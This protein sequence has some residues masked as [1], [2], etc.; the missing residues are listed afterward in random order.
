MR[1]TLLYAIGG[2]GAA[3]SGYLRFR[4][5]KQQKIL[6]LLFHG[7]RED[8][9]HKLQLSIDEYRDGR[10]VCCFTGYVGTADFSFTVFINK[11]GSVR[12]YNI[13]CPFENSVMALG[14]LPTEA[15][16]DFRRVY[17]YLVDFVE[18]HGIKAKITTQ[19]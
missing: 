8:Q 3:L 4:K 16:T 7:M 9:I 15:L 13:A 6:N 18:K 19:K 5:R 2:A 17:D 11:S 10:Q 1:R 14:F 12:L